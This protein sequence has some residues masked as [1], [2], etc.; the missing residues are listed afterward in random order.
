MRIRFASPLCRV[1]VLL[2]VPNLIALSF[3]I[4]N[5]NH[6]NAIPVFKLR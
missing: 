2:F 6:A 1:H 5:P 3:Q 4:H